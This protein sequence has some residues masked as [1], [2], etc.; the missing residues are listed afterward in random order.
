MGGRPWLR[1][2]RPPGWYML[3][4]R[5]YYV[6]RPFSLRPMHR[7]TALKR[8]LDR[9]NLPVITRFYAA[10]YDNYME[11]MGLWP[12][13]LLKRDWVDPREL[14]YRSVNDIEMTPA[15]DALLR[16]MTRLWVL[17][18]ITY[19]RRRLLEGFTDEE[20]RA[21]GFESV[22][23]SFADTARTW[24]SQLHDLADRTAERIRSSPAL[25]QAYNEL[26]L[27]APE[28]LAKDVKARVAALPVDER[29]RLIAEIEDV[30]EHPE[31]R[32]IVRRGRRVMAG[33]RRRAAVERA[34]A[35]AERSGE[36]EVRPLLTHTHSHIPSLSP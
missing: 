15:L 35:L 5:D 14:G 26:A 1:W 21:L 11:R 32:Y 4:L 28:H 29:Q 2:P 34:A 3:K 36:A 7:R 25:Q 33:E 24:G 13:E 30:L 31:D 12:P 20:L 27:V 18:F 10:Y 23:V 22:T 8:R 16:K 17:S 6:Y 9:L 19:D